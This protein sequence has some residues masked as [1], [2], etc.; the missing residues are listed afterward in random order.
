[1][2]VVWSIQGCQFVTTLNVLDLQPYDMVIGMDWLSLH[3]PMMVH[4][5][6]HWLSITLGSSLVKL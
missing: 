1:M 3:S 5:A 4:W 2:D 6:D